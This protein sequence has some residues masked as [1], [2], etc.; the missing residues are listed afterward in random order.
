VDGVDEAY[1]LVRLEE[2]HLVGLDLGEGDPPARM[3]GD[4]PA[5]TAAERMSEELV[6]LA[7][8]RRL[9]SRTPTRPTP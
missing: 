1:D 2:R 8:A 7:D 4:E 9:R 5:S 6:R 3:V